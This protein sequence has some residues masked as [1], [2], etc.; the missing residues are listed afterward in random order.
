MFYIDTYLIMVTEMISFD[1]CSEV[2]SSHAEHF[3][4]YL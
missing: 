4:D 3:F 2:V 1:H